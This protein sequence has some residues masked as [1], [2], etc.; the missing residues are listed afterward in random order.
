LTGDPA[1]PAPLQREAI[2]AVDPAGMLDDVLDL[3]SHLRDAAWRVDSA[4]LEPVPGCDALIV[5]GM[6]GSAIGGSLAQAVLGDAAV[7]PMA[8]AR[9]YELPPWATEHTM[10]LCASYSGH[11]EE[12]LAV[13]EAAGVLGAPRIA[14]TTG[15]RLAELAR[16][17]GVPIVPLPGGFQPRAAVAYMTVVALEAAALAG[18]GPTVRCDLDVAGDHLSGLVTEWGPDGAEDGLA[19]SVA[20]QLHGRVPVMAGAQLT[21][22]VAYRW[23]CQLNENAKVPASAHELPELDHNEIAGWEGAAALGPHA[24]V[25][26][27]DCDLHPRLRRRIELTRELVEPHAA[28][29]IVLEGRGES[30]LERLMSLV[31]LGDLVSVYLAVLQGID[32]TP[33]D[34]IG[35]LKDALAA[36]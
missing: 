21:A 34:I 11:T 5:A 20:R 4:R 12:T 1:A 25:F 16:A 22:P 2:A 28:A 14:A 36:E 18:V 13:Y 27:D 9:G 7:L 29:T 10:V 23:K 32:P 8:S 6:G 30:R 19:K 17:E 35:R 3:P 33:A 15:G 24:A 26:L 31:L